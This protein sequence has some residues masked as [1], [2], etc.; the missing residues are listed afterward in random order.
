VVGLTAARP[1]PDPRVDTP[2]TKGEAIRH[3]TG[4]ITSGGGPDISAVAALVAGPIMGPLIGAAVGID[5]ETVDTAT[6]SIRSVLAEE[7]LRPKLLEICQAHLENLGVTMVRVIDAI[8]A[9]P[10]YR[11]TRPSNHPLKRHTIDLVFGYWFSSIV[12]TGF[13]RNH[14]GSVPVEPIEEANPPLRL[15]LCVEFSSVNPHDGSS[16]GGI[17]VAYHSAS[18]HKFLAWARNDAAL[19]RKE[20][21]H[22]WLVLDQ[23]IAARIQ[24]AGR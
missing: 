7:Q 9:E 5:T 4:E 6:R 13:D 16:V 15:S 19:L 24:L 8:P 11:A 23:N 3:F 20:M 12:L 14:D 2:F 17:T 21:N 1:L 22:F 18:R 10:N